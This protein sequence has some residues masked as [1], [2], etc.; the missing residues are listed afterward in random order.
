VLGSNIRTSE[1]P[2][3][4]RFR[5]PTRHP[6]DCLSHY[7]SV[8]YEREIWSYWELPTQNGDP[9]TGAFPCDV[10]ANPYKRQGVGVMDPFGRLREKAY[11]PRA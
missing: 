4:S 6:G 5:S 3:V 8:R 10:P 1:I 7:S 11:V 2:A 9:V